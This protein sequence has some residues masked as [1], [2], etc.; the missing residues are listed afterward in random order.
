MP[1]TLET[2]DGQPVDVTPIDRAA[3]NA[4]FSQA[5]ND[6]GPDDKAPPKRQPR[7]P[8]EDKPTRARTV[9]ADKARATAK[10]AVTLDDAQRATGVQGLAQLGAGVAAMAAKASG[11][12]ALLADS[13]TI[14]NAAPAVADACVQ[15]AKNDPRFAAVLDRVCST[16]P[17]GALITVAFGVG[18][19]LAR[20]H[21]PGLSLPGTVHPDQVLASAMPEPVAA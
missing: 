8:A 10:P 13:L 17:Y 14:V 16:G 9:K 1:P 3:V 5:M 2:A 20:N 7:Q 18:M 6:D 12:S 19:Q 11:S 4:S 15:V 21:K